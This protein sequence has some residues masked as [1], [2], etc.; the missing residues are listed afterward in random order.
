MAGGYLGQPPIPRE[1]LPYFP[2]VYD[3]YNLADSPFSGDF[4]KVFIVQKRIND[5]VVADEGTQ[6][7]RNS[8]KPGPWSPQATNLNSN[9]KTV[10]R[11]LFATLG[12]TP[13]HVGGISFYKVPLDQLNAYKSV[14]PRELERRSVAGQLGA[15]TN[16][17]D[18]YLSGGHRLL[19]LN[20][21]QVQQLGLLPPHWVSGLDI[22]DPFGPLQNGLILTSLKNGDVLVGVMGSHDTLEAL[23]GIYRPSAKLIE[24]SPLMAI[25]AWVESTRWILLIEY[26]RSGLAAAAARVPQR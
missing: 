7:W 23:A 10:I 9:E 25:A 20:P 5:V 11:S 21:V 24:I 6:V 2:I 18:Q 17:A 3:L 1:Y 19:S 26:D 13:L 16:A 12:V 8:F 22:F 4:L 14:D 15:L